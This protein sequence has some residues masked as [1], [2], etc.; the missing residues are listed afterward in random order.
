MLVDTEQTHD[1]NIMLYNALL[2]QQKTYAR[3]EEFVDQLRR[4]GFYFLKVGDYGEAIDAFYR[5]IASR[6]LAISRY[7]WKTPV[8]KLLSPNA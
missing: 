2:K 8:W 7:R 3:Q 5:A 1:S 6:R 4:Y